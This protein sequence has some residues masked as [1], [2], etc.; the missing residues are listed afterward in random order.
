MEFLLVRHADERT[1][2]SLIRYRFRM[3]GEAPLSVLQ[4]FL[5]GKLLHQPSTDIQ[6][7]IRIA[8][9]SCVELNPVLEL[10][11]VQR[12]YFSLEEQTMVLY[13]RLQV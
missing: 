12:D 11:Q 8:N 2:Q 4:C 3:R 7:M 9:G 6:I 1:L 5:S 10:G 13:Y